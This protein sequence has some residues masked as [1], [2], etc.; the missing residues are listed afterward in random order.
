MRWSPI[1]RCDRAL[2]EFNARY[3]VCTEDKKKTSRENPMTP[4]NEK[5][6]GYESK[7]LLISLLIGPGNI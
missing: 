6:T 2:V 3:V 1:S 4:D 5:S 7:T